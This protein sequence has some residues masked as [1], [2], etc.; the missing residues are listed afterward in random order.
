MVLCY[1]CERLHLPVVPSGQSSQGVRLF[2]S[3]H[4]LK[5]SAKT[6]NFCY[7]FLSALDNVRIKGIKN[8][9]IKLHTWA[10]DAQGDPVGTSRVFIKIGDTVGRFVDVYA[11]QGNLTIFARFS[12]PLL[13]IFSFDMLGV[14]NEKA[15]QLLRLDL[16]LVGTRHLLLLP[17]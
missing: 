3:L 14:N 8:G 17:T 4:A 6:C 15:V 10:S 5:T 12:P 13:Q 9:A 1:T 11:E 2:S 7:L 16:Q